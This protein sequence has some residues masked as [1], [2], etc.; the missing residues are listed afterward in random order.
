MTAP[1]AEIAGWYRS[2][3]IRRPVEREVPVPES[4]AMPQI[5]NLFSNLFKSRMAERTVNQVHDAIV[6]LDQVV[7][8]ERYAATQAAYYQLAVEA[9]LRIKR[10]DLL[11]EFE[12]ERD[13]FIMQARTAKPLRPKK[14]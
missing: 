9:V 14:L 6:K 8:R 5:K 11:A 10:P 4:K 7:A 2:T 1:N 3:P 12:K 13:S